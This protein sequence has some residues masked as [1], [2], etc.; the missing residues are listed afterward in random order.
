MGRLPKFHFLSPL[1]SSELSNFLNKYKEHSLICAGG[2]QLIPNLKKRLYP[3]IDIIISLANLSEL[4]SLKYDRKADIFE[5]GALT[6]LF[7]IINSKYSDLSICAKL[8]AAPP[9]QT[10]ATIGGNICLDTRCL[11]YNQSYEWRK[12]REVCFKA[13]G[14]VCNAVKGA[15]RCFAV[16]SADL[17]PLLIALDAEVEVFSSDN[18]KIIKLK[19][20]YTG[21]GKKPNILEPNEIVTKVIIRDFSKKKGFYE[22]F[23]IRNAIDYP[24]AGVAVG[25]YK[26]NPNKINIVL[27]AVESKPVLMENIDLQKQNIEEIKEMII[28]KAKP[29]ANMISTPE[30]RK[31]VCARLF[32]KIVYSR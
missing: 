29:V 16:F 10:K 30:Y 17:P 32:E 22:K 20:F 12:V 3:D 27:N 23:R 11:Y 8:I 2:T 7:D 5:I 28:K 21:K 19:D 9:I 6:T 4:K 26:D 1:N 18:I 13:G 15:K 24:L 25:F 31:E 14:K